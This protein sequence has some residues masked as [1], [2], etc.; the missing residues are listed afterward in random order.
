MPFSEGYLTGRESSIWDLRRRRFNQSEIGRRLG[1]TRQAVHK[2]WGII[3]S[4]V[5]QAFL[6]VAETNRLEIR[7]LNLAE[8]IMEAFSPAYRKLLPACHRRMLPRS[9]LRARRLQGK[10]GKSRA[11]GHAPLWEERSIGP[12][13][14]TTKAGEYTSA[15]RPV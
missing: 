7:N 12:Y 3:D 5:E 2:A 14:R 10:A 15:A 4:K 11:R 13:T 1:I 6:E 8:G 9:Y